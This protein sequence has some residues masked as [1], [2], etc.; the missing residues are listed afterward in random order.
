MTAAS[1][2]AGLWQIQQ[3]WSVVKVHMGAQAEVREVMGHIPEA[4]VQPFLALLGLQNPLA[5]PC[6]Q[7]HA[8]IYI[9]IYVLAIHSPQKG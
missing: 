8:Y 1:S 7:A 5:C 6:V 4:L 3:G 2:V 9:Y